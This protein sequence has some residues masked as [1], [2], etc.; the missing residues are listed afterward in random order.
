MSC[1]AGGF[2]VWKQRPSFEERRRERELFFWTARQ[3]LWLIMLTA[4][5]VYVV[6]SLATGSAPIPLRLILPK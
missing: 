1:R 5:T 4:A 6:V 2:P 3:S